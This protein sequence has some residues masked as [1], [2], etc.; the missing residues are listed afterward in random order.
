[1]TL[2][3]TDLI[4]DVLLVPAKPDVERDAVADAWV[5]A[6]GT[7]LRID[8]FWTRP[9]VQPARVKPLVP[10]Q[11]RARV[12]RGAD[13]LRAECAGLAPETAVITSEVVEIRAEA[14]AWIMDGQV[15]TCAVY[16]GD[17]D[18]D[19][20]AR[21][22]ADAITGLDLPSTCVIDAALIV[23]GW[24]ILEANASWGAGL[25]G[26]AAPAAAR[27]IDRATRQGA[28]ERR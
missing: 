13:E 3:S 1:M 24:C 23:D 27:C 22:V 9:D 15:L 7:V 18:P 25:D 10:K 12:W 19:G 17:G 21:F 5:D 2:H 14:R 28:D 8:R 16:D 11:F 4:H 26:C 6:G 20:A